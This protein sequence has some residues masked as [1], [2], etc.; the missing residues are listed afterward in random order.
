[1]MESQIYCSLDLELTGFDPL[2]DEVLEVGFVFFSL[3]R[4]IVQIHESWSQVFKPVKPV[5]PRILALTG[6]TNAEIESAPSFNEYKDFLQ[7]KLSNVVLV[8]HSISVDKR[9]LEAHGVHIGPE[10]IDTLDL[11]QIFLPTH[12]SYNLENLMHFLGVPHIDAHRALAD[13]RATIEIVKYFLNRYTHFPKELRTEFSRILGDG[14]SSLPWRS[15][16]LATPII[17]EA[18]Y[19][20]DR[21]Q[22]VPKA[23]PAALFSMFQGLPQSGVWSIPLIDDVEPLLVAELNTLPEKKL[24]VLRDKK[25]LMRL[26]REFGLEVVFSPKDLFDANKF[27]QWSKRAEL[28]DLERKFILKILVWRTINWQAVTVLDLNVS[29]FGGQFIH[30]ITGLA[31]LRETNANLLCVDYETYIHLLDT[32]YN[33]DRVV[34]I[35]SIDAFYSFLSDYEGYRVGWNRLLHVLR[36]YYNPELGINSDVNRDSVLG[37]IAAV[38]LFFGLTLLSLKGYKSSRIALKDI[39]PYTV[40]KLKMAAEHCV[41]KLQTC[42]RVIQSEEIKNLAHKLKEFFNEELGQVRW[43]EISDTRCTFFSRPLVVSESFTNAALRCDRIY[44][45]GFLRD[46]EMVTFLLSRLNL[47]NLEVVTLQNQDAHILEVHDTENVPT[48]QDI[49]EITGSGLPAAVLFSKYLD[50]QAF[51]DAHY[52]ELKFF[53]SVFALGY[54]GG[55]LKLLKNY[56]LKKE[57]ILLA[58]PEFLTNAN[59]EGLPAETVVLVGPPVVSL[60]HPYFGA[61][62][63]DFGQDP[64]IF[65]RLYERYYTQVIIKSFY[66]KKLKQIFLLNANEEVRA[67]VSMLL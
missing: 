2:T 22:V 25:K 50:L 66:S 41:E 13:A 23:L 18:E 35:E 63:R 46:P 67:A 43:I 1:M 14:G 42:N 62:A 55:P 49:V 53:A 64:S 17:D 15:W 27:D 9:F 45:T 12:H 30:E 48:A 7:G 29:F 57:S 3:E 26:Y 52:S 28:T 44:F 65:V 58:T 47:R 37:G 6:I 21:E 36:K 56:G 38:D 39:E 11:A 4:G 16:F 20:E 51:Y 33:N 34:V 24:L 61:L 59:V 31:E 60:E 5:R 10:P 8:G 54:S 19:I 32:T 40:Y